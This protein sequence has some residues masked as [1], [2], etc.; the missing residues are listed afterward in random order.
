[1]RT[2]LT[3]SSG[4]W[5]SLLGQQGE[6]FLGPSRLMLELLLIHRL[7]NGRFAWGK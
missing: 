3:D 5:S 7:G 4:A 6:V 1:M 2:D